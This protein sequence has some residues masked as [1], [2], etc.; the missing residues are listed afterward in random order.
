VTGFAPRI[1]R[2]EE[3]SAVTEAKVHGVLLDQL[4]VKSKLI[5][6]KMKNSKLV[7]EANSDVVSAG[8]KCHAK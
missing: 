6:Q 1:S 7:D 4:A 2:C 8:M 5:V 3:L